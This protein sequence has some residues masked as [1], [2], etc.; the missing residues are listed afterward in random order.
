MLRVAATT[1][2]RLIL[3]RS[4]LLNLQT[5]RAL[6]EKAAG[7]SQRY[8]LPWPREAADFPVGTLFSKIAGFSMLNRLLV[9]NGHQQIRSSEL[10]EGA[11]QCVHHM[12]DVLSSSSMHSE[13]EHLLHPNLYSAVWAALQAMP[14][15]HQLLVHLLSLNELSLLAV[16]CTFGNAAP[17]DRHVISFLGQK[18]ITSQKQLDAT[19][20]SMSSSKFTMNNAKELGLEAAVKNI[21]I[22]FTVSFRRKERVVIDTLDEVYTACH[23]WKFWS[24]FKSDNDYPLQWTIYD[25]NH[26]LAKQDSS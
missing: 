19:Y 3:T 22:S 16:N 26:F 17:D 1:Y 5:A 24:V 23:V 6:C 11:N 4:T 7:S 21:D 14:Q 20:S 2:P 9:N 15:P 10:L 18:L 25:I 8:P 12:A 13:L